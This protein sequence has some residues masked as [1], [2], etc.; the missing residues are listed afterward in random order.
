LTGDLILVTMVWAVVLGM[1]VRTLG[2][3]I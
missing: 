1:R 3:R 2:R